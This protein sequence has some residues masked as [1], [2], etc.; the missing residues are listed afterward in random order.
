[1]YAFDGFV[2]NDLIKNVLRNAVK[3]G[4]PS[5]AYIFA[6]APGTGKAALAGAFAKA[7]QCEAPADGGPCQTCVSCRA[8]ESGNHP[9]VVFVA[10][11]SRKTVGVDEVREQVGENIKIRP[12]K[13]KYKIFII[14]NAGEMTPQAQNALLKV[15]EEPAGYGVFLLTGSNTATILP[16]VLSRSVVLKLKPLPYESIERYL[17]SHDFSPEEAR[18]YAAYARGSVGRALSYRGDAQFSEAR[19]L[20]RQTVCAAADNA[21]MVCAAFNAAAKFEPFKENIRE[22]LEM[23]SALLKDLLVYKTTGDP[24]FMIERFPDAYLE[25]AIMNNNIKSLIG[26]LGAVGRA[27]ERLTANANFSMTMDVLMMDLLGGY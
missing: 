22:V 24:R 13:Y 23:M 8:F 25:N 2:G 19:E 21:D 3:R 26:K 12:Y 11:V 7:L 27:A 5:H 15:L 18:L 20:V 9:D 16:T 6:G 1:M 14:K 17:L 10:P 4:A